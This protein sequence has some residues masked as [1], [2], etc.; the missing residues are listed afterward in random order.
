MN[1]FV[2]IIF[3][4]T[5]MLLTRSAHA[6]EDSVDFVMG[7]SI[8]FKTVDFVVNGTDLNPEYTT[9]N[10][11]FT[12]VYKDFYTTVNLDQSLRD[13]AKILF[14]GA[15]SSAAIISREDAGVTFGYSLWKGLSVF[16][17][18]KLGRT[19]VTIFS[20]SNPSE[21]NLEVVF[22]EEGLFVGGNYTVNFDNGKM[23]SLSLGFADLDGDITLTNVSRGA[24]MVPGDLTGFSYALTWSVPSGDSLTY[25]YGLRANRYE[26]KDTSGDPTEDL[27]FDENFTI[28]TFGVS[29][30]F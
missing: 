13:D 24:R 6:E 30:Y 3:I 23:L 11:A 19:D 25:N 29:N 2:T 17:G 26:F 1:K 20:D 16:G 28:I 8:N 18:Y 4:I 10:L 15:N 21:E 14:D 9:V 12:A 27:S 5:S 7:T 22:D